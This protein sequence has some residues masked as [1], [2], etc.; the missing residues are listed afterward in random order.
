M[1][2]KRNAM[3]LRRYLRK[4]IARSKRMRSAKP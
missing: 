3:S 2:R 4:T 1:T